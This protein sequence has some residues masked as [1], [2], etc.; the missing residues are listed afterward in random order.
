MKETTIVLNTIDAV[1]GEML[2]RTRSHKICKLENGLIYG[3]FVNP[4]IEEVA[5]KLTFTGLNPFAGFH[6]SYFG[7][8]RKE[9]HWKANS[10]GIVEFKAV[11]SACGK[12]IVEE[13]PA[14]G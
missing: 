1:N 9:E 8:V 7:E 2:E 12:V 4:A 3:E 5:V 11:I 10:A 6:I 13:L 14:E